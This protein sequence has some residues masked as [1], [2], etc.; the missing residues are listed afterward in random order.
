MFGEYCGDT[1]PLI[2]WIPFIATILNDVNRA[3]YDQN[4]EE[5][6]LRLQPVSRETQA[7]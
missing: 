1:F 3:K 6:F 2:S 7:L 4:W 5:M